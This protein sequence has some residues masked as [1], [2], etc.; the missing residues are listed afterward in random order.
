MQKMPGKTENIQHITG[1]CTSLAQNDYTHRHNQV[2]C[3]VHQAV[4]MK[5]RLFTKDIIFYY[6][7]KPQLV[8]ENSNYKVYYDRS[9]IT[10]CTIQNNRADIVLLDKISRKPT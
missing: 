1:G 4:A 9:I 3:I 10:D 2:A 8:L 7:Y 5:I 6:K